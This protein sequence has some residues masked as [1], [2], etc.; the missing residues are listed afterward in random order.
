MALYVARTFLKH[1]FSSVS[2]E[3]SGLPL[4]C[5]IS[6]KL[7]FFKFF[8]F[9]R[10]FH[11]RTQVQRQSCLQRVIAAIY[12]LVF[13]NDND[14][15]AVRINLVKE[16]EQLVAEWSETGIFFDNFMKTVY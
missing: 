3:P 9:L 4:R 16:R 13:V 5:K 2:D 14:W 12:I 7:R 8:V 1:Q 10:N 6:Y 11:S 15:I